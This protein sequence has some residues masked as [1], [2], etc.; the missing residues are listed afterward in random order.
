M[1]SRWGTG[2]E[3]NS[4]RGIGG[5]G[6]SSHG[7]VYGDLAGSGAGGAVRI[8]WGTGRAVPSTN[9]EDL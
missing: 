5:S 2:G 4:T 3:Y 1:S 7:T 6:G 9:T 8:I